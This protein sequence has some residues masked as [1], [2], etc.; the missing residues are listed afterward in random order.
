M[1]T[2]NIV[3]GQPIS[4]E[5]KSL[6]RQLRQ[7]MT[8]SEKLLWHH[9]RANRLGGWHFRRQ[10]I[11]AGVIVDFYCH[12]AGLVIEVDGEIHRQQVEYDHERDEIIKA[13]GLRI[14]RIPAQKVLTDIDHVLETISNYCQEAH[15]EIVG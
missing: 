10:Q 14:M 15:V 7:N 8:E 6:A 9:L 2:E 4:G 3:I 11:I 5:K 1:K 12:R 13:L